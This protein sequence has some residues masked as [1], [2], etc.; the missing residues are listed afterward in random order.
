MSEGN[1]ALARQ[2]AGPC[3]LDAERQRYLDGLVERSRLA[4]AAFSQFSQVSTMRSTLPGSPA[5]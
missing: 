4:A 2:A 1:A 3:A 5:A